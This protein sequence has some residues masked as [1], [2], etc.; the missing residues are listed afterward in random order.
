M[1]T[2]QGG[3]ENHE[4]VYTCPWSLLHCKLNILHFGILVEWSCLEAVHV[5][6]LG[7]VYYMAK[8]Q[9]TPPLKYS[10]TTLVTIAD[11]WSSANHIN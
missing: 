5:G 10:T 2:R 6:G 9:N 11:P 3:I 7:T 8:P 4:K 1:P